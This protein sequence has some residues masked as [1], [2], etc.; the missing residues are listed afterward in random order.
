M[1]FV[2]FT[3]PRS[4]RQPLFYR[5]L[6]MFSEYTSDFRAIG[7]L[8][9]LHQ[10][11][12][13]KISFPYTISDLRYS[14]TILKYHFLLFTVV[15]C[16]IHIYIHIHICTFNMYILFKK[17]KGNP[18]IEFLTFPNFLQARATSRLNYKFRWTVPLT[19]LHLWLPLVNLIILKHL[20]FS[21]N[22]LSMKK[23][24]I[25]V[26]KVLIYLLQFNGFRTLGLKL[27][28]K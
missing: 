14:F 2:F 26:H 21:S 9:V 15:S 17:S 7:L 3:F 5:S 19:W 16:A 10:C 25:K 4:P 20:V 8:Q 11:T 28:W 22:P 1:C 12:L 24:S 27:F 6:D 18:Y 23:P 13:D